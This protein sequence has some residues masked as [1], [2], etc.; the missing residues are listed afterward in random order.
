MRVVGLMNFVHTIKIYHTTCPLQIKLNELGPYLYFSHSSFIL[1]FFLIFYFS[2]TKYTK[3]KLMSYG[4]G[5]FLS[6]RCSAFRYL[7]VCAE[8]ILPYACHSFSQK[9]LIRQYLCFLL[10]LGGVLTNYE[11]FPMK[12]LSVDHLIFYCSVTNLI[13]VVTG[14]A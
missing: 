3:Y 1:F 14:F 2:W 10:F 9:I 7:I 5:L 13:S 4:Y 11:C 8:F 6:N 12:E